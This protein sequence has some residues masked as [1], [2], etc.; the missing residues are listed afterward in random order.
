ME[1][2]AHKRPT[3]CIV[4]IAKNEARYVEEWARYHLGL[5]FDRIHLYDNESEDGLFELARGMW[6]GVAVTWW[7]SV[8]GVS[9]QLTA[10]EHARRNL[11]HAYDFLAFIDLDE[12][13]SLAELDNI[14]DYLAAAPPDVGAVAVNQKVFGSSG[15][16]RYEPRP[17]LERFQHCAEDDYPEHCWFKSIYRGGAI[18]SIMNC[19]QGEIGVGRYVN[20]AFEDGAIHPERHRTLRPCF[21][22]IQLNHYMLKSEEEFLE[23]R[24]RGGGMGYTA[25]MRRARYA[26]ADLYFHQ[27]D[28]AVNA[29]ADTRA[30]D[31][32]A[33]MGPPPP[34]Q[35][36]PPP[37]RPLSDAEARELLAIRRRRDINFETIVEEVYSQTVQAGDTVIDGGAHTGRHTLPLASLVGDAGAV[38]GVEPAPASLDILRQRQAAAGLSNV[39]LHER[40]LY[41]EETELSLRFARNSGGYSSLARRLLPFPPKV[42]ALTVKTVAIDALSEAPVSFIKLDLGGREFRALKG[43]A[44]T[45]RRSLPLIVTE[46]HGQRSALENGYTAEE[47]FELLEEYRYFAVD[48]FGRR[49]DLSRWTDKTVPPYNVLMAKKKAFYGPVVWRSARKALAAFR[50]LRNGA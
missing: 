21:S 26:D 22:A 47:W 20:A 31:L 38:I 7:P 9:P 16:K 48:L 42:E 6:P 40:A 2:A 24:E 15:L 36:P 50:E 17:V 29:G 37:D 19:H 8:E 46:N 3:A 33:A 11:Q 32:M 12:F 28:A 41:D 5:G 4:A 23:K 30:F 25:A 18:V 43:A 45:I 14:K 27:R 10:Y 44:N 49:F 1:D 34:R 35:P 13:I 39:V